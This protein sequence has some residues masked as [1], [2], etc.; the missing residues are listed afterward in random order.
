[1]TSRSIFSPAFQ[2]RLAKTALRRHPPNLR[3]LHTTSLLLGKHNLAPREMPPPTALSAL[4]SRLSLPPNPALHAVLVSCLTHPSYNP[5][6]T[7]STGTTSSETTT[8]SE[9]PHDIESNELLCALGN[10]LLG[11]FASEHL[12]HLYPLL[13]TEALKSAVTAYVGPKACFSVARELGVGVQAGGN[14]GAVGQGPG[15]ISA[16]VA[17]RWTRTGE[18]ERDGARE[19][20]E[21]TPVAKRFRKYVGDEA[22]GGEDDKAWHRTNKKESFEE[23]IATSVKAFVGLIYQ[24]QVSGVV[25]LQ[26]P[27]FAPAMIDAASLC[28]V[29]S[30]FSSFDRSYPLPDD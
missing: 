4:L 23:I 16:G 29:L 30:R 5:L 26:T 22:V 1:M 3:S 13:P 27:S 21:R 24:E 12:A 20:P 11:L 28:F 15:M 9:A 10:S 8:E 7:N 25:L 14:T 19:Q 6:P 17:L 18:R 2:R